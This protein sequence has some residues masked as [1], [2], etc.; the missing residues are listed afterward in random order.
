MKEKDFLLG[1]QTQF[2]KEM[3]Q[4][5]ANKL[6]C[7][8]ATHGTTSYDFQLF[9]VLGIDNYNEVNEGIPVAWFISNGCGQNVG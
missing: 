8:N 1:L 4:T 9:A 2:Q 7:I 6:I 3:F 5:D